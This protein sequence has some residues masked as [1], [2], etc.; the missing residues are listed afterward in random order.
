MVKK[1][2]TVLNK[3]N[4]RD[5]ID[6]EIFGLEY[7][8]TLK[9]GEDHASGVGEAVDLPEWMSP[10]PMLV[11]L[12]NEAGLELEYASNFHEFYAQRAEACK[13]PSTPACS[14]LYNMK[15][16]D[17]NGSISEKEWEI[18]GMYMAVK[19][20]KVRE[21]RLVLKEE[22]EDDVDDAD[23]AIP[24]VDLSSK[25]AKNLLPIALLKAKKV[26][27]NDIWGR[28]SNEEKKQR[29]NVE[30]VKLLS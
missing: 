3:G 13:N 2:F 12:G 7:T 24:A 22:D 23:Q 21:S 5:P 15:V 25:K 14:A 10:L 19:F 1:L 11:A 16:L 17:H 27:G 8:F 6:P 29:T 30:L 20:K 28:I 4:H 26:A 18:S 9:E